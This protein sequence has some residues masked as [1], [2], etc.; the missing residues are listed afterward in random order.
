[1]GLVGNINTKEYDERFEWENTKVLN[2][3]DRKFER[4]V[5]KALEMQFQETSLRSHHGLNQGYGPYEMTNF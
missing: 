1:M 3:E 5:R 4:K 2:I